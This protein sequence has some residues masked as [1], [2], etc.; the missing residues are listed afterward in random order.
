MF[1]QIKSIFALSCVCQYKSLPSSE[2]QKWAI[3]ATSDFG[4]AVELRTFGVV[5]ICSTQRQKSEPNSSQRLFYRNLKSFQRPV[6]FY[7]K[8]LLLL[9]S[10]SW[11]KVYPQASFAEPDNINA[12]GAVGCYLLDHDLLLEEV[13]NALWVLLHFWVDIIVRSRHYLL[14]WAHT[15]NWLSSVDFF[16]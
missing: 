1:C 16:A 10:I 7:I 11:L 15:F 14:Q 3:L 4:E 6:N 5:W 2:S 9:C 12:G 8:F 13:S